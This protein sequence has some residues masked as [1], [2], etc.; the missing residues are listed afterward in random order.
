MTGYYTGYESDCDYFQKIL[1]HPAP[2]ETRD[3]AILAQRVFQTPIALLAL[4][5]H[6]EQIVS[7]I[8]IGN[9]WWSVIEC[10]PL[11][12]AFEDSL[13]APDTAALLPEG[14]NAGGLGFFVATPV[15]S[16]AGL[17]LGLLILADNAPRTGFSDADRQALRTLV[18]AF[19]ASMEL[20]ALASQAL[21]SALRLIE[22]EE[23][24]RAIANSAPILIIY[25][26]PDGAPTFVNDR[27]LEF[28]GRSKQ[29]EMDGWCDSIHPQYRQSVRE[30]FERAFEDR[31]PFVSE[32]PFL[33]KDGEYRWMRSHGEPRHLENGAFMGYLGCLVDVNGYRHSEMEIERLKQSMAVPE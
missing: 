3:L 5:D 11:H 28:T 26:G 18:N 23:R 25:G 2:S 19:T 16:C 12:R 29:E 22:T 8:G 27:W 6:S 20:R 17:P 30:G 21:A 7:R 24:F 15:R 9:E 10:F 31:I 33:R 32:F 14:S 13:I 4:L 1:D